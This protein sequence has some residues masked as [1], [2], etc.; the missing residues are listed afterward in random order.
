MS[1]RPPVFSATRREDQTADTSADEA[2]PI[3]SREHGG[4]RNYQTSRASLSRRS[5]GVSP[6]SR[7]PIQ[8]KQSLSP[9]NQPMD[10][11]HESGESADSGSGYVSGSGRRYSVISTRK[12]SA[13]GTT[14]RDG[15]P[16]EEELTGPGQRML[17][18]SYGSNTRL[19][20]SP[21]SASPG[22]IPASRGSREQVRQRVN[23]P[24]TLGQDSMSSPGRRK[25]A[26][27]SKKGN[28]V[29]RGGTGGDGIFDKE[30]SFAWLKS[31]LDKYGAVE[32]DNKGSVAR[33]HLALGTF[34]YLIFHMDTVY[35]HNFCTQED[36]NISLQKEPSLHGSA[37][38]LPSHPSA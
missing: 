4:A 24:N 28:K 30:D 15:E 27:R 25:V 36:I 23:I 10:G 37:P 3:I 7:D 22:R 16:N 33:D 6:G 19:G 31:I 2:D 14:R 20:T 8:A 1:L 12:S 9:S 21:A 26:R 29:D 38:L 18:S 11:K 13:R 34:S 17:S 5:S 35:K 32:L